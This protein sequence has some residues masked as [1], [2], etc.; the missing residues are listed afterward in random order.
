M[1]SVN[2]QK[3]AAPF[4]ELLQ[5]IDDLRKAAQIAIAEEKLEAKQVTLLQRQLK[6]ITAAFQTSEARTAVALQREARAQRNLEDALRTSR[7]KTQL[8][9]ALGHDL[10]QPLTV[11]VSALEVLETEVQP[12]RSRMLTR[13]LMAT[14]RLER[15]LGSLMEAAQL[16]YGN[17]EAH[18]RVFDIAPLLREACDQHQPDADVKR[19]RL[20]AVPCHRR[21]R[22]DPLLLGSIIHNLIEN[23]IKYTNTGRILVGCRPKDD[24]LWVQVADTGIGIRQE[25]LTVIFDEYRQ[26][27]HEFG[28]G[29]GLGL[30]I[31]KRSADLLGHTLSV[32]S[33]FG[34]GSCFAVGVP[35]SPRPR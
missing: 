9:A 5:R 6:S 13:A 26:V 22:S 16:E 8:L 20:I 28:G 23:A 15:A 30:F 1:K 19:L 33:T 18:L 27:A 17:I 25:M 11:I 21:V 14:A 7:G 2:K 35:L 4:D 32:R 34:A 29:V 3:R 12:N 24:T 10:R 31:V